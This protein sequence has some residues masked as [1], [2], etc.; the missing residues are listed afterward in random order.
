[1]EKP[2]GLIAVSKIKR[3]LAEFICQ[4]PLARVNL[5]P[6][7]EVRVLRAIIQWKRSIRPLSLIGMLVST[8]DSVNLGSNREFDSWSGSSEVIYHPYMF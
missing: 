6:M 2:F 5:L 3:V 4:I 1:M 8:Q 7:T